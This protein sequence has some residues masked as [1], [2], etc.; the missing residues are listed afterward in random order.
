MW[1]VKQTE[2]HKK[3]FSS[4]PESS[5]VKYLTFV[6]VL[7]EGGPALMRP[8]V[9]KIEGSRHANM[10]ELIVDELPDYQYRSLFVFDTNREAILLLGGNKL[11]NGTYDVGFYD[12]LIPRADLLV[13]AH[14]ARLRK[15]REKRETNSGKARKGGKAGKK[16]R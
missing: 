13:D 5:K 7:A 11:V 4:L 10:K 2:D 1:V 9:G 3:W 6:K 15:E 8:Y 16:V 12:R 14:E